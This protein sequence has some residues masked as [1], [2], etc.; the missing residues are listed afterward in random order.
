M[1][2]SFKAE[3][4]TRPVRRGRANL[5][6]EPVACHGTVTSKGRSC[7]PLRRT[8]YS[9]QIPPSPVPQAPER[10]SVAKSLE[11]RHARLRCVLQNEPSPLL[12]ELTDNPVGISVGCRRTLAQQVPCLD[13]KQEYETETCQDHHN[14]INILVVLVL[15][16]FGISE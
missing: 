16:F 2:E 11:A 10:T 12:S 14:L 8:I 7:V 9:W 13:P 15:C 6:E 3:A 4:F 5:G 1:L